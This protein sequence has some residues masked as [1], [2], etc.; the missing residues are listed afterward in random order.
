MSDSKKP[1][2]T[3]SKDCNATPKASVSFKNLGPGFCPKTNTSAGATSKLK[4]KRG[5][6]TGGLELSDATLNKPKTLTDLVA[7]ADLKTC[8]GVTLN[9]KYEAGTKK[10][11]LGATW[12]GTVSDRTT[13]LKMWY[14]NKNNMV[15]GEVTVGKAEKLNV[16][17]TQ[18]Q[19][20]NAKYT[21]PDGDFTYEPSYNFVKESPSL[22][23]TKKLSAKDSLKLTYD[24]RGHGASAEWARKPFKV[25]LSSNIT[26][27]SVAKPTLSATFE[28]TYEF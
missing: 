5:K 17:F 8:N 25:N 21:I 3:A 4:L 28:N 19:L 23:V 13:A 9:T 6:F 18:Q 26:K 7:T 1:C 10:Y 24:I 11:Q 16:T 27:Q 2:C 20:L 22:A 14:S 15:N 12:N